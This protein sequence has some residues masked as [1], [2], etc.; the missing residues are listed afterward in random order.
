MGFSGVLLTCCER[1]WTGFFLP[2]CYLFFFFYSFFLVAFALRN[3]PYLCPP[4]P[5]PP[6]RHDV[7]FIPPR[8]VHFTFFF[9][10]L[11]EP[12]RK[13]GRKKMGEGGREDKRR[14]DFSLAL[15]KW[16]SPLIISGCSRRR[17]RGTFWEGS[18]TK[19]KAAKGKKATKFVV[20]VIPVHKLF[21]FMETSAWCTCEIM[22]W[23]QVVW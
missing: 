20:K 13:G 23:M 8:K 16:V 1:V 9:P 18:A 19:F 12:E 14:S 7:S 2:V 15:R 3:F 5:P 4:P 10:L 11:G 22:M 6:R 21:F 17:W